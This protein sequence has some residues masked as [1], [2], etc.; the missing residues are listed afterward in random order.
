METVSDVLD[1]A[2]VK[3][4]VGIVFSCWTA[5]VLWANGVETRLIDA[6]TSVYVRVAGIEVPEECPFEKSRVFAGVGFTKRHAEYTGADT[7]YPS[8]AKDGKL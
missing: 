4:A 1:N 5:S 8:W 2:T 7:W 6:P 3:I